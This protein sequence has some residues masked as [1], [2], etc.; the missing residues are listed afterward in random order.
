MKSQLFALV[1]V[2]CVL[3]GS[4][5]S[6]PFPGN[7]NFLP[8]GFGFGGFGSN[9]DHGYGGNGDGHYGRNDDGHYDGNGDDHDHEM[10]KEFGFDT[11]KGRQAGMF[12][13][14]STAQAGFDK[15]GLP[16]AG[17]AAFGQG[18]FYKENDHRQG[19]ARLHHT[20][21]GDDWSRK[22]LTGNSWLATVKNNILENDPLVVQSRST[23]W[24]KSV[25]R[26]V[27]EQVRAYLQKPNHFYALSQ[28]HQST[29]ISISSSTV[30]KGCKKLSFENHHSNPNSNI[31]STHLTSSAR[32]YN[33]KDFIAN[34]RKC[35][36]DIASIGIVVEDKILAFS[37]LTKLP[38]EFHSLIEKVTLNADTK[39]N[40]DTILNV[41]HEAALKEEAL[42]SDSTKA[43]VLK[44][45]K[46]PSK[47]VHYCSNGRHNPLV[48]THGPEKYWQLNPEL[49]PERKQKQKEQRTN[50]TIAQALFT[51]KPKNVAQPLTLVL[52]TG[53]SNH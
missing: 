30:S 24:H 15:N 47:V 16:Q 18:G 44:K 22:S 34:T 17:K 38:E 48:T 25:R 8:S 14:G 53:T 28:M 4:A 33:L 42:F 41:L 6:A 12:E 45:D 3:L 40:P 5:I 9:N 20:E 37:I 19:G 27:T 29:S 50:F 32:L 13:A 11:E 1:Q 26:E 2:L 49:K 23:Q 43:L 7:D 10:S 21:G 35:L 46:L 31:N 51:Y 39:G 36:S 52:D